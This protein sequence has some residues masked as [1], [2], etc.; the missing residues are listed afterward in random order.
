MVADIAVYIYMKSKASHRDQC[1]PLSRLTRISLSN[2]AKVRLDAYH[3]TQEWK[4]D[5]ERQFMTKTVGSTF[6][7]FEE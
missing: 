5:T 4:L 7:K 6:L 1:T 3:H 2:S